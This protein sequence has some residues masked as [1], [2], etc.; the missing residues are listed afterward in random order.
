MLV[1]YLQN[2][3]AAELKVLWL[4]RSPCL[5]SWVVFL[6]Y[7]SI[8]NKENSSSNLVLCIFHVYWLANMFVL[9]INMMFI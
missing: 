2:L 8:V 3:G 7:S 1:V 6:S 4:Q 5:I 9:I